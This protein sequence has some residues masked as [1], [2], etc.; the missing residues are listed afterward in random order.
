MSDCEDDV[1]RL[2]AETLA[3]LHEFYAESGRTGP[4]QN[5]IKT[6]KFSVGAVEED[7][8]QCMYLKCLE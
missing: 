8:V 6:D 2:S 5:S 3:A 1:P 4:E 7:W